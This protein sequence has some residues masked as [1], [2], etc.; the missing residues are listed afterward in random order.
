MDDVK[1]WL[2]SKTVWGGIVMVACTILGWWKGITVDPATQA[3][4]VDT[5]VQTFTTLGNLVG[6]MLA[7]YGRITA[8]KKIG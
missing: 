5:A 2:A 4:V 8:T 3:Q 6:G 7:I 1:S